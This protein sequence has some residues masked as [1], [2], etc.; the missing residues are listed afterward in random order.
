MNWYYSLTTHNPTAGLWILVSAC[1]LVGVVLG[2]GIS[3]LVTRLIW[4][5]WLPIKYQRNVLE[6]EHELKII[7]NE[8][9][10]YQEH[11]V[12]STSIIKGAISLLVSLHLDEEDFDDGP[13]KQSN[14]GSNNQ[15]VNSKDGQTKS[16]SKVRT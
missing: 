3:Y 10:W 14:A 11:Y 12:A 1:T 7:N 6:F 9:R 5:K 4:R 13:T 8:R 15:G 16:K 2:Y